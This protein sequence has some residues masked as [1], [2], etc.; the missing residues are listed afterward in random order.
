MCLVDNLKTT[1][2]STILVV[3]SSSLSSFIISFV[4]IKKFSM[5][6][7]LSLV[8]SSTSLSPTDSFSSLRTVDLLPRCFGTMEDSSPSQAFHCPVACGDWDLAENPGLSSCHRHR[9]PS[10][11]VRVP[12]HFVV[13]NVV[14]AATDP[15]FVFSHQQ[16]PV[17]KVGV[18]AG[19]LFEPGI[20]ASGLLT[21]NVPSRFPR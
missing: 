13:V 19:P 16:G 15:S 17:V 9:L 2:L 1:I 7:D 14:V 10:R 18:A 11:S 5:N 20:L 4:L 8:V 12:R 3:S 6:C 21:T